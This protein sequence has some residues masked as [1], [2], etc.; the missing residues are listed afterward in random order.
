MIPTRSDYL[1]TEVMTATPQKLQLMLIEA[2]LRSAHQARQHWA[3]EREEAA[4]LALMRSQNILT[5]LLATLNPHSDEL[6]EQRVVASYMFVY[7]SLIAANLQHSEDQ[8]DAALR[9]LEVERETW[10]LVCSDLGSSGALETAVGG[11]SFEA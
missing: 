11:T 2:A 6:V 9:V 3:Q 1:Y 7:R 4:S 5:E 10:R 8:L